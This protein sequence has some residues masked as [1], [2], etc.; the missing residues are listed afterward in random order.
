M[1][2]I[3]LLEKLVCGIAWGGERHDILLATTSI[4]FFNVTTGLVSNTH[5]SNTANSGQVYKI[6][7][8]GATGV[9]PSNLCT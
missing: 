3:K 6:T 8:L 9:V 1:K 4:P 7:G 2:V 5:P